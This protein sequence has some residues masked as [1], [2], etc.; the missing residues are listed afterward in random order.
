MEHHSSPLPTPAMVHNLSER[1]RMAKHRADVE[2]RTL[3]AHPLLSMLDAYDLAARESGEESADAS[4]LPT[5]GTSTPTGNATR[6]P[7]NP[8]HLASIPTRRHS[9][10][11]M[12]CDKVPT[13]PTRGASAA[14]GPRGPDGA[15][16]ATEQL[17]A[18]L[19]LRELC[20]EF[21]A[22]V[23]N[24]TVVNKCQELLRR[25]HALRRPLAPL[26]KPPG[27]DSQ[28]GSRTAPLRRRQLPFRDSLNSDF[29]AG[30]DS[31]SDSGTMEYADEV[32]GVNLCT[33]LVLALTPT[34]RLVPLQQKNALL[35]ATARDA[36]VSAH[37]PT[38]D[39]SP[40]GSAAGSSG[41]SRGISPR[42]AGDNRGISPRGASAA[43][44]AHSPLAMRGMSSNFSTDTAL[45]N[46]YARWRTCGDLWSSRMRSRSALAIG[47]A[48]QGRPAAMPGSS[49]A[50]VAP[51]RTPSP[52]A[53]PQPTPSP[54]PPLTPGLPGQL[55]PYPRHSVFYES[56]PDHAADAAAEPPWQ[57]PLQPPFQGGT[58][59]AGRFGASSTT[60]SHRSPLAVMPPRRPIAPEPPRIE[61]SET[62]VS[63][64]SDRR[65]VYIYIVCSY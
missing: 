15:L 31:D 2:V 39:S 28:N 45:H 10:Q 21:L 7:M 38:R 19:E 59:A 52:P 26:S 4:P 42:G 58:S 25:A 50:P 32:C 60:G 16:L 54:P 11:P 27:R 55:P 63:A 48:Q 30:T 37:G 36:L 6:P 47:G 51:N 35:A 9:T 33:R 34:A 49:L 5:R 20:M 65:H 29:H 53:P 3:L 44:V 22:H 56:P 41:D 61:M 8:L 12:A 57:Q 13:M 14:T 17:A 43:V 24:Q 23:N 40:L 18:L 64:G 1:S 46:F 62:H